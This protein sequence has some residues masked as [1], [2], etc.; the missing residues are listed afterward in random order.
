MNMHCHCCGEEITAPKFNAGNPYGWACY[1]KLFGKSKQGVRYVPVEG[2]R[3]IRHWDSCIDSLSPEFQEAM[4]G[5]SMISFTHPDV[6]KRKLLGASDHAY[7][8]NGQWFVPE[9]SVKQYIKEAK[10]RFFYEPKH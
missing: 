10:K 9:S 8:H 3:V 1:S 5:L 4:R 7:H 6:N 2:V